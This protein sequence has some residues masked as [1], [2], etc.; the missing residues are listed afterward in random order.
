[1]G[2]LPGFLLFLG[3]LL[4]FSR[5]S[6]SFL[7]L[8]R[9]SCL[10]LSISLPSSLIATAAAVQ[11]GGTPPPPGRSTLKEALSRW[12]PFQLQLRVLGK[13][14]FRKDDYPTMPLTLLNC[15]TTYPDDSTHPS[16]TDHTTQFNDTHVPT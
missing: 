9:F 4:G 12:D 16:S 11:H 15:T 5:F 13:L 2:L 1:M 3:E 6:A 14:G 7:L 10:H 8:L